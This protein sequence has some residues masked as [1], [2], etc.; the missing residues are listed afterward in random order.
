[1]SQKERNHLPTF[2]FPERP[3]SF[4][5]C[6]MDFHCCP[7]PE[8]RAKS[9]PA[10]QR[11]S[12]GSKG[13]T[14]FSPLTCLRAPPWLYQTA[15]T[16]QKAEE[17]SSILFETVSTARFKIRRTRRLGGYGGDILEGKNPSKKTSP[18][19]SCAVVFMASF[20]GIK[21]N[22]L[23]SLTRKLVY[24]KCFYLFCCPNH[25]NRVITAIYIFTN[26]MIKWLL[27]CEIVFLKSTTLLF[28]PKLC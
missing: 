3:D 8:P 24:P 14:A 10:F 15:L 22:K 25:A 2:H 5:V 23:T 6:P 16:S 7:L 26:Q 28:L 19:P 13:I 11:G 27:E 18:P 21:K 17:T 1:M 12:K 9:A 20:S 4:R